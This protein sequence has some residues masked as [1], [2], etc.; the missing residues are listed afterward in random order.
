L[1]RAR[2]VKFIMPAAMTEYIWTSPHEVDRKKR[3]KYYR[4]SGKDGKERE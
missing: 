1:S 4:R 2:Y 3:E